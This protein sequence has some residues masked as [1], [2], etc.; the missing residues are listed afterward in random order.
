[1]RLADGEVDGA[2]QCRLEGDLVRVVADGLP[3]ANVIV[4][5]ADAEGAVQRDAQ[6]DRPLRPSRRPA[7]ANVYYRLDDAHVRLLLDVSREH[8]RHAGPHV[9]E[10]RRG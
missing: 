4:G 7:Q 9:Q 8:L 5:V 10:V 3:R 1:M 6:A 2:E